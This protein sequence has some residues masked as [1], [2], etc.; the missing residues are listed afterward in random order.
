VINGRTDT[1]T[2]TISVG[3]DPDGAA[4][5]PRTGKIYVT[6]LDL[7]D[8]AAGTVSVINGR[9]GTVTG[10]ISV[11][12]GAVGGAVSPWTGKVYVAN[13]QDDTVSVIG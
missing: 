9:T 11:G 1:V 5:S 3:N 4:V 6:N 2:V 13:H 8:D 12:A 7:A 10:T